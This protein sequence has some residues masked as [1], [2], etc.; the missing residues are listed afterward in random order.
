M[1]NV[2]LPNGISMEY[3]TFGD[4]KDEAVFLVQGLGGQ[5][6]Q[7]YEDF[8]QLFVRQKY[9]VVRFDNRDIGIKMTVLTLLFLLFLLIFF[10]LYIT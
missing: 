5:M 10:G 1:P 2:C 9:F 3:E 7:W 8:V 4:P 6:I